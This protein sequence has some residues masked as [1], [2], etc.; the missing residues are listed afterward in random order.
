MTDRRRPHN[1]GG[2]FEMKD[3]ADAIHGQANPIGSQM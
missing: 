1:R 3:E 2:N